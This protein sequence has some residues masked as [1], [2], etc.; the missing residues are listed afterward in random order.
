MRRSGFIV[1]NCRR[2]RLIAMQN[3]K[4]WRSGTVSG[5]KLKTGGD[6]QLCYSKPKAAAD[7]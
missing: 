2:L 7:S 1:S 6:K 4:R 3:S 5:G